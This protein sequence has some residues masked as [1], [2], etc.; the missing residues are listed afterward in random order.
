MQPSTSPKIRTMNFKILFINLSVYHKIIL[1]YCRKA[2]PSDSDL[3]ID[4][5]MFKEMGRDSPLGEENSATKPGAQS[6]KIIKQSFMNSS[7]TIPFSKITLPDFHPT[8]LS[9]PP[10]PQTPPRASKPA[11][12]KSPIRYIKPIYGS[13]DSGFAMDS[14]SRQLGPNQEI[15]TGPNPKIKSG[16]LTSLSKGPNERLLSG[17][18]SIPRSLS[19]TDSG[20]FQ[21]GSPVAHFIGGTRIYRAGS[22]PDLLEGP[23]SSKTTGP[24]P[25]FRSGPSI[26]TRA[27]SNPDVRTGF[28]TSQRTGSSQ[29]LSFGPTTQLRAGPN[30]NLRRGPRS[31]FQKGS[32]PSLRSGPN[33]LLRSQSNSSLNS[34]E[35][36]SER[37]D[38][39]ALN[40]DN[41]RDTVNAGSA[42]ADSVSNISET[43]SEK[44]SKPI[45]RKRSSLEDK[46]TPKP[47]VENR[48]NQISTNSGSSS[49]LTKLFSG[50]EDENYNRDSLPS[51]STPITS[52]ADDKPRSSTSSEHETQRDS[53]R[54]GRSRSRSGARRTLPFAPDEVYSAK[55]RASP[56][57]MR[58]T[59][60]SRG[61]FTKKS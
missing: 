36:N 13:M 16:R 1:F 19:S 58:N 11:E 20:I 15:R 26:S 50:N 39:V 23:A 54:F 59:S 32:N 25:E 7:A 48:S 17:T 47:M 21:Q 3:N 33:A 22:N 53:P 49:S 46:T 27:V 18:R 38:P 9:P 55:S 44:R 12:E 52:L 34:N 43:E 2:L 40:E 61:S 60:T 56:K 28:Y 29:S 24:N 42:G 8:P 41:R 10:L 30:Q 35:L 14:T 37:Y 5:D 45:P 6:P 31:S 51:T 4:M 57:N